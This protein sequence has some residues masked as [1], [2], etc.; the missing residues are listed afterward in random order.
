MIFF[1]FGTYSMWSFSKWT[2][3]QRSFSAHSFSLYISYL[4]TIGS[5]DMKYEQGAGISAYIVHCASDV[6][7]FQWVSSTV[8]SWNCFFF[9]SHTQSHQWQ[10]HILF[11]NL[12][13]KSNIQR[14]IQCRQNIK[15]NWSEADIKEWNHLLENTK[16][17]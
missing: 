13:T 7:T 14:F 4:K 10:L 15:M 16:I 17:P 3:S 9:S 5:R 11:F 2:A 12:F 6:A 8:A 1:T